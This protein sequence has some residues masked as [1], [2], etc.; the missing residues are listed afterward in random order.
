MI[1]IPDF[2]ALLPVLI[3]LKNVTVSK[4]D[5]GSRDFGG[6]SGLLLL[7]VN[8]NRGQRTQKES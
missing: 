6:W 5:G 4:R 2:V 3:H 7:R 8:R 1:P